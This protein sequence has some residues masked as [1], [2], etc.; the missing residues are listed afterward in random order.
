MGQ[1]TGSSSVCPA[2]GDAVAGSAGHDGRDAL[3]NRH[4]RNGGLLRK[5]AAEG[6]GNSYGPRRTA[7]GS[8]TGSVGTGIQTAH[9]WF[10]RRIAPRNSSQPSAGFHRVSGDAARSA[11][12][13]WRR[14]SY[15]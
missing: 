12:I 2:Y 11:G 15:V 4:L 1:G 8:A 3:Y 10:R 7:K 9:F 5:Q 6:I 13:G 14:S